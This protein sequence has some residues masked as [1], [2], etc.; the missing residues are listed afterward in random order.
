MGQDE[1]HIRQGPGTDIGPFLIKIECIYQKIIL[2]GV[3]LD[4]ICIM[5]SFSPCYFGLYK[6]LHLINLSRDFRNGY[7]LC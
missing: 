6:S 5:L 7:F 2:V 4:T 3:Y 1:L